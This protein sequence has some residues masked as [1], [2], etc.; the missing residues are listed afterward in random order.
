MS[1]IDPSDHLFEDWEPPRGCAAPPESWWRRLLGALWPRRI[2]VEARRVKVDT[3]PIAKSAAVPYAQIEVRRFKYD[4]SL[5]MP[6]KFDDY[7]LWYLGAVKQRRGGYVRLWSM[8][9]AQCADAAV[10]ES[11]P[12]KYDYQRFLAIMRLKDA[13]LLDAIARLDGDCWMRMAAR[14]RLGARGVAWE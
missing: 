12:R 7:W 13:R 2:A 1:R 11:D 10:R 8:T 6:M 3:F 9:L 5:R 14:R 4:P